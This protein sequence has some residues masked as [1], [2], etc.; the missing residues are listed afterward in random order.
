MRIPIRRA[1]ISVSDKTGIEELASTFHSAGCEIV[2]IGPTAEA[3]RSAG[4][5]ATEVSEITSLPECLDSQIKIL[6]LAVRTGTFADRR[7]EEY[8]R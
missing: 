6:H 2:L 1:A 4:V 7:Y 8:V 5:S 3:I